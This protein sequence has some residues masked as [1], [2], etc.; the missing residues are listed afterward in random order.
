MFVKIKR[1]PGAEISEGMKGGDNKK[2]CEF[3]NCRIF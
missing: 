1:P 2:P 3:Q